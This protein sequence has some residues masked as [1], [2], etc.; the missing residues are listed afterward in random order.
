MED[1]EKVHTITDWYDGARGGVADLNGMPHYYENRWDE[2]EQDW[3]KVY[4]L[5]PL[6]VETFSLALED[7]GIWLRWEKAFKEGG[8]TQETHPAL[9][10]DRQRHTELEKILAQ[11]LTISETSSFRARAEFAYGQPTLVKWSTEEV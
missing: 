10:E 11:R 8:T 9:P 4:F 7:W 5:T 6:D 3:S 1:F 2:S